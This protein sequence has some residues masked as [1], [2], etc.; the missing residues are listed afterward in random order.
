MASIAG[1]RPLDL[2]KAFFDGGAALVQVRAKALA[3][4]EQLDVCLSVVELARSY[5]AGVVVNDRTDLALLAGAAGVHVGQDDLPV[6]AARALL[7]P[8]AIVGHSTHTQAQMERSRLEPATYSAIGPVF[9]TSTK[10]TG[11]EAVG[12]ARVQEAARLISP[13]PLVAIGGITL[14]LAPSV[15][16][17][18]AASV[19]VIS[20][21][22]VGNDPRARVVAYLR[23]LR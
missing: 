14:E 23:T 4:G 18:G 21:F 17:A 11:Y 1:W 19:A 22:L 9:G 16:A 3:S 13:R 12:L 5:G 10:D 15:I 20:D 6:A 2:A 8:A 7:G